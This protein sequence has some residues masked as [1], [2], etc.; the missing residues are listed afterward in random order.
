MGAQVMLEQ[1]TEGVTFRASKSL[2]ATGG[3]NRPAL[4]GSSSTA[5][6]ST[7]LVR[8]SWGNTAGVGT[9]WRFGDARD[10]CGQYS[11]WI[12]VQECAACALS[13][14]SVCIMRALRVHCVST[15]FALTDMLQAIVLVGS[16]P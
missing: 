2:G 12:G 14:H 13:V 5:G 15:A 3:V 6:V 1:Y 7:S 8:A 4:V 10:A 11:R 9:Y 16:L